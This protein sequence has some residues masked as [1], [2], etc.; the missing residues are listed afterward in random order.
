[1]AE[2]AADGDVTKD[3][4]EASAR[5]YPQSGTGARGLQVDIAALLVPVNY[6]WSG[7]KIDQKLS[8]LSYTWILTG[9]S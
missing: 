4:A 3:H 2:T 5:R 1:M 8:D 6:G 7:E 9:G